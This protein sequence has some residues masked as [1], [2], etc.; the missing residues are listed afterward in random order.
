MESVHESP[1]MVAWFGR[2]SKTVAAAASCA[3]AQRFALAAAVQVRAPPPSDES[4]QESLVRWWWWKL[5]KKAHFG[6]KSTQGRLYLLR[7]SIYS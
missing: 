5:Q 6:V 3:L 7:V 1:A 4:A 2:S